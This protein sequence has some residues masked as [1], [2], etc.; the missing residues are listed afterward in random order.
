M[1]LNSYSEAVAA[2]HRGDLDL[3]REK[4]AEAVGL[5]LSKDDLKKLLPED[6]VKALVH[7]RPEI[8]DAVLRQI[9]I[10][11]KKRGT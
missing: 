7:P 2:Y 6:Q 8:E 5:D 4:M 9:Q 3:A 11:E 1:G 10:T